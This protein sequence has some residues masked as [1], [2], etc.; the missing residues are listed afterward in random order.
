MCY[1]FFTCIHNCA[2]ILFIYKHKHK[3]CWNE[4]LL[5]IKHDYL[6]DYFLHMWPTPKARDYE[7]N[8]FKN[9]TKWFFKNVI[10]LQPFVSNFQKFEFFKWFI[11]SSNSLNQHVFVSRVTCFSYQKNFEIICTILYLPFKTLR[12]TKNN[13]F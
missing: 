3:K 11:F 10:S 5:I 7:P 12:W 6:H 8:E 1:W 13:K 2:L 4:F 9:W